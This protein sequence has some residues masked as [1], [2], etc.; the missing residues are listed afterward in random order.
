MGREQL[1]EVRLVGVVPG[2]TRCPL[3]GAELGCRQV[4]LAHRLA[5]HFD[6]L[7]AHIGVEERQ[8]LE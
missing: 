8:E 7:A 3:L 6:G 2:K 5:E 4:L 1:Q